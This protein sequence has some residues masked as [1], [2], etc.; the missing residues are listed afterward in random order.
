MHETLIIIIQGD[1]VHLQALYAHA[2]AE[3][4]NN[5][6]K[7]IVQRESFQLCLCLLLVMRIETLLKKLWLEK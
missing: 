6:Y 2:S 3:S 5:L 4:I 1:T 7:L